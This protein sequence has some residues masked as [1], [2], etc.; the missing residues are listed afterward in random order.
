VLGLGVGTLAAYTAARDALTFYE[1]DP[2]MELAA[3]RYFTYLSRARGQVSVQI[4]DGRM[5]LEAVARSAPK[6]L[7]VLVLDAF[8]SD[9]VPTHLLTH[10]AF[11]TY[12]RTL[13]DDGLLL[14]NVSNRHL[15]VERVVADS[16][17]ANGLSAVFAES[18]GDSARG[19]SRVRWGVLAA[20]ERA[21]RALLTAQMKRIVVNDPLAFTDRRA[22]LW[23][24]AQGGRL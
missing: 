13:A 17:R 8:S 9:S 15:R 11:A 22:S 6:S 3:R 12:A 14:V 23:Q 21:C 24:L 7:D 4:D 10:E 20:D 5:A 1:I 16:A 2:D 19:L 18:A